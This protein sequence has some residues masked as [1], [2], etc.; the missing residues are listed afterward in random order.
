VAD[1]RA[2][3][4]FGHLPGFRLD[5]TIVVADATTIGPGVAEPVETRIRQQLRAADLVVLN[6]ADLVSPR[7]REA[8]VQWLHALVPGI[9]VVE[10][11]HARV[12][13]LLLF[14]SHPSDDARFERRGSP[15]PGQLV[16]DAPPH[17]STAYEH[18]SWSGLGPLREAAFRKW[19][20]GLP[21]SVLRAKGL[22]CLATDPAHRFLFQRVGSHWSIR[23][24]APWASATP[25]CRMS[26][27]APAGTLDAE[28]LDR[29][30][31]RSLAAPM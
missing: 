26:L 8:A 25:G 31:A 22:L 5:G 23:R 2:I 19:V 14:G 6:K 9:Q 15:R 12:P 3:A 28:R 21:K 16:S 7:E 30:I 11:S 29:S 10:T 1:P 4:Q 18:W 20:A 27:I 24:D 13:T 17:H